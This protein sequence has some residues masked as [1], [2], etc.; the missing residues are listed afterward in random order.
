M[1]IVADLAIS[2]ASI[3][4]SLINDTIVFIN[5]SSVE[6][7]SSKLSSFS[8]NFSQTS[9]YKL[10]FFSLA[11]QLVCFL[12]QRYYQEGLECTHYYHYFLFCNVQIY[13]YIICE[14]S[15]LIPAF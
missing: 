1:S 9:S 5:N 8:L 2:F 3:G 10:V 4:K 13:K 12:P 6:S 15:Y 14:I 7:H 11:D